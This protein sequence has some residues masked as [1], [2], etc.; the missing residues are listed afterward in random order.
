MDQQAGHTHGDARP[1]ELA[2]ALTVAPHLKKMKRDIV[3]FTQAAGGYGITPDEV[4][5]ATGGLINTIRRRFTDLWKEGQL[6]PT[7]CTRLNARGNLETIWVIGRDE[8]LPKKR[9]EV[10]VKVVEFSGVDIAAFGPDQKMRVTVE[11][12]RAQ[13]ESLGTPVVARFA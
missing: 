1:A 8:N 3:L 11:M 13:W 5:R 7:D 2:A 12:T 4:Q 6:R 9:I 10:T